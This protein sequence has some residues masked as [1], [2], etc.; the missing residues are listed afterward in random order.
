MPKMVEY[1]KADKGTDEESK[2]KAELEKALKTF[3]ANLVDNVPPLSHM[4][5]QLCR[6]LPGAGQLASEGIN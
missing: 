2:A 6:I 3:D 4:H 1:L 5:M